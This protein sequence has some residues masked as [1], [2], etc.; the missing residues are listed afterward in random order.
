MSE[1]Y[2]GKNVDFKAPGEQTKEP[3]FPPGARDAHPSGAFYRIEA[4]PHED[5]LSL[6]AAH[7]RIDAIQGNDVFSDENEALRGVRE[8]ARLLLQRLAGKVF[9]GA[10]GFYNDPDVQKIIEA[11]KAYNGPASGRGQLLGNEVSQGASYVTLRQTKRKWLML[12]RH[13]EKRVE[14]SLVLDPIRKRLIFSN[15][16]PELKNMVVGL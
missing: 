10:Q 9:D 5:M 2:K 14:L 4:K 11:V 12:E 1:K 16:A 6:E 7:Q 13:E 15:D 8:T 3:L